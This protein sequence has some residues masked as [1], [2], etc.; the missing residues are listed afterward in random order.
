MDIKKSMCQVDM[1][2]KYEYINVYENDEGKVADIDYSNKGFKNSCK[3]CCFFLGFRTVELAPK[4]S[5]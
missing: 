5:L 4:N 2:N 3:L 1:K